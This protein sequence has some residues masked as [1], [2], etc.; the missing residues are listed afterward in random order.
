M[1]EG[2]P[3]DFAGSLICP[4][5]ALD[6]FLRFVRTAGLRR[7]SELKRTEALIPWYREAIPIA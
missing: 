6:Y 5:D 4:W 2:N 7:P 1:T 3:K